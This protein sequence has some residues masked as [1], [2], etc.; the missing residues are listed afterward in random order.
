MH[1]EHIKKIWSNYIQ[2]CLFKQ[3]DFRK[4]LTACSLTYARRFDQSTCFNYCLTGTLEGFL[5]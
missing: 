3:A 2:K 1:Q 5:G 4:K